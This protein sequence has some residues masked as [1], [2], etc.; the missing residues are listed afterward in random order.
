M[1]SSAMTCTVALF[2]PYH[3]YTVSP[4]QQATLQQA[5]WCQDQ[6]YHQGIGHHPLSTSNVVI[7][8]HDFCFSSFK[9]M[10]KSHTCCCKE[11]TFISSHSFP[12]SSFVILFC[13]QVNC[14]LMTR[15]TGL[16][17][18]RAHGLSPICDVTDVI[19]CEFAFSTPNSSRVVA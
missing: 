6:L 5:S 19:C 17:H 18:F 13:C 3:E 9:T 1:H 8:S 11:S 16:L 4:C 14:T 15:F 12:T 10:A 7:V 2:V